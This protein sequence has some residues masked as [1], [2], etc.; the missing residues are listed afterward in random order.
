MYKKINTYIY[1]TI[2]LIPIVILSDLCVL[3][4]TNEKLLYRYTSHVY[5]PA[6]D[7][8]KLLSDNDD[9]YIFKPFLE[10][11]NI[12]ENSLPPL[13]YFHSNTALVNTST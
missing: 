6:D 2:P 7:K 5:S 1:A 8:L 13:I 4:L 12:S 11:C 3:F 10:V 9:V